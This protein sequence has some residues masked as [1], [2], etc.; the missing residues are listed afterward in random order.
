MADTKAQ[1]IERLQNARTAIIR[2]I[3]AFEAEDAN[4]AGSLPNA[5]QS[6]AVDHVGFAESLYRRLKYLDEQLAALDG[7]FEVISEVDV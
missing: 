4:L 1:L 2:R 5:S 6:G 3:E 7:S